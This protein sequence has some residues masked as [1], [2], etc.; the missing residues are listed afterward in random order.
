MWRLQVGSR[1]QLPRTA[2]TNHQIALPGNHA[3]RASAPLLPLK[4]QHAR[5][6]GGRVTAT[7]TPAHKR[8]GRPRWQ[9]RRW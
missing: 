3:G 9:R 2:K 8:P 7:L 1:T 6:A 4:V 5:T